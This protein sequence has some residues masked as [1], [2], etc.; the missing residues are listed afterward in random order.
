[1]NRKNQQFKPKQKHS[2]IKPED[3][4]LGTQYAFSFNPV[5][6]PSF[7][8]FYKIR[9]CSL[10]G[11][12]NFNHDLFTGMKYC[13]ITCA[14]EIS[15]GSRFHY[16]GIIEIK[17]IMKFYLTDLRKLKEN[18]SY[19]IDTIQDHAKWLEYIYK[20]KRFV[21]NFAIVNDMH[22]MIP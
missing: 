15:A 21:E 14:L 3:V 13:K 11:W 18:G 22:Y 9:L 19:E 12:S 8:S 4:Q 2:C 20:Q 7:E 6:Q 10:N 5:T 1:M 16:H 17:D